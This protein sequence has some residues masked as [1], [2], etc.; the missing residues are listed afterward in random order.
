MRLI[1]LANT[2][3]PLSKWEATVKLKRD[4]FDKAVLAQLA[5]DKLMSH[6]TSCETCSGTRVP[7]A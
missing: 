7:S 5:D 1:V 6:L 4:A 3:W 2:R